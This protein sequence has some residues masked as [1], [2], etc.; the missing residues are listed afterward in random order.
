MIGHSVVAMPN[1]VSTLLRDENSGAPMGGKG[2][3]QPA[4]GA[5][6]KGAVPKDNAAMTS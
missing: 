1:N 5:V 2:M 4:A 3:R 6:D